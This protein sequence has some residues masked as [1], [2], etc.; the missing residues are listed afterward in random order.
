MWDEVDIEDAGTSSPV[1]DWLPAAAGGMPEPAPGRDREASIRDERGREAETPSEEVTCGSDL[2]FAPPTGTPSEEVACGSDLG[3]APLVETPS[4]GDAYDA[5]S[6]FPSPVETPIG[7]PVEE[8]WDTIECG[9]G[10]R[11]RGASAPEP[12]LFAAAARAPQSE[13]ASYDGVDSARRAD[14]RA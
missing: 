9:A 12:A 10:G 13:A 7:E 8:R 3:F 5:D 6:A 4:G 14:G 11:A 2:G 1:D